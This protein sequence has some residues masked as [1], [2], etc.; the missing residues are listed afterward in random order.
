MRI[1]CELK[2]ITHEAQVKLQQN[3]TELNPVA[4]A[5]VMGIIQTNSP[6]AIQNKGHD[7]L[8]VV[9]EQIN[10]ETFKMVNR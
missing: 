7:S 8:V 3:L 5:E 6:E 10:L 4:L 1:S 9:I 2:S